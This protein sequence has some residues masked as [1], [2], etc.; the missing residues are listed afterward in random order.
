MTSPTRD[1]VRAAVR[2]YACLSANLTPETA[3]ERN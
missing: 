3:R 1:E 2:S